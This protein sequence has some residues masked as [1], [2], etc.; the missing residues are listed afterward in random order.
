M[1][2]QFNDRLDIFGGHGVE[3]LLTEL[4]G[5]VEAGEER[6][7]CLR[8]IES[9]RGRRRL[10]GKNAG[11]HGT[12]RKLCQR[13]SAAEDPYN[14]LIEELHNRGWPDD[15]E[16]R[17]SVVCWPMYPRPKHKRKPMVQMVL[18]AI[19]SD[20]IAASGEA[21]SRTVPRCLEIEHLMPQ[22]WREHWPLS[23]Q[24]TRHQEAEKERDRAIGTLGNLTLTTPELNTKLSN[25]CWQTKQ[26]LLKEHKNL[27]LTEHLLEDYGES[28]WD[29]DSTRR[30][31]LKLAE[32]ICRIWPRAAN[33]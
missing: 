27:L 7:R 4:E 30:R 14:A 20:L 6:N 8:A 19:E 16:V 22:A 17:C 28:K 5:R 32:Y 2:E 26:D 9:W 11:T 25:D 18:E 12:F 21:G 23:G 15:C 33:S 10:T 29:E 13:V 3:E 1:E 24:M 31:G